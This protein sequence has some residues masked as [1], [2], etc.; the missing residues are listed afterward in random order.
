MISETPTYII[1]SKGEGRWSGGQVKSAKAQQRV[2]LLLCTI[3]ALQCQARKAFLNS[4]SSIN[5]TRIKRVPTSADFSGQIPAS[6]WRM[7]IF[8]ALRQA[9]DG[10]Q[11]AAH[12]FPAADRGVQCRPQCTVQAN[13]P[14][15][16]SLEHF[17]RVKFL[18][19]QPQLADLYP[20]ELFSQQY[21]YCIVLYCTRTGIFIN[22]FD[23]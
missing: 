9:G 12:T 5:A 14:R 20:T 16:Q 4:G 10:L 8:R 17:L 2:S 11:M 15:Q 7:V 22:K 13:C 6:S 23:Q 1:F 18:K 3:I 21:R 19:K